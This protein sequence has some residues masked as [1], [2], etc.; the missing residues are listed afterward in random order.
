MKRRIPAV[1][2]VRARDL[3]AAIV[4]AMLHPGLDSGT[5]LVVRP[6]K[7]LPPG[8]PPPAAPPR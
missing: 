3:E 7:P 1:T 2:I 5:T 4:I 8:P 6:L